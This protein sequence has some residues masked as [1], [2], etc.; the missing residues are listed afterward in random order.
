[1]Q[2]A[3][4]IQ[5]EALFILHTLQKAGFTGYIVGGAV[6]DTLLQSALGDAHS[7]PYLD[8]TT[9]YDFTTNATP[10]QIRA[11]FPESFCENEFGTVSISHAHL[12]TQMGFEDVV[13][14]SPS[15]PTSTRLID[16]AAATKLHESLVTE[17]EVNNEESHPE[18]LNT[19]ARPHK[20]YEITTYRSK[21][22]YED[23]RRPSSLQW[24]TSLSEDLTRRDFTINALAIRV[25]QAYLE[26]TASNWFSHLTEPTKVQITERY[27]SVPADSI[28][29]IDDHNGLSD[30]E[31]GIIR[32]VGNP[33]D[34]FAE[35]AL[36][37]LRT[38]RFSVQLN[39]SIEPETF[40]ALHE[41]HELLQHISGERIR[42]EFLKM[43]S[44]AYPKEAV[45]LLE[46]S[47][48]LEFVL[49]ELLAAKGVE[50]GGHHTTDVWV[51]SLDALEATPSSDPIVRLA[52][53][54]HDIGKPATFKVINGQPTFYNHEIV[55][56]RI[57]KA[58]AIRLRLSK[59]DVE[60][61]FLLVRHHMF[62]YQRENSDAA[63]RRFM[64]KVGLENID[65]ILDLREADRL[66]SGARKT[67]WRLEEMNE[68]MR[69]QLHQPMDVR[70]LAINGHDLMAEL[71]LQPGRIL[72]EILQ[73]LFEQVLEKPELNTK[74]TLLDLA[75]T[76]AKK[77]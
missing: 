8:D 54:L 39:M 52:T 72:G 58:I 12:L 1:M 74:A 15:L 16:I 38:I 31:L 28:E 23:F 76:F 21:E 14:V 11:L 44:S 19:P 64:R 61:I 22:V 57:A 13:F 73:Y 51:H 49:P 17:T 40:D 63:I 35:D 24:G 7:L 9:D 46:E 43:L 67:S 56:S 33:L 65:D 47:G 60:R 3:L 5:P 26:T 18:A 2:R 25:D 77:S 20:L 34:R 27:R 29:L 68:R 41:Q 75:R 53:L 59:R 6:R 45:L 62:H 55:G 42:D 36:R 4:P 37:M 10:E 32:T 69:A 71:H 66:G 50:Q 70:D 48:L 30:L